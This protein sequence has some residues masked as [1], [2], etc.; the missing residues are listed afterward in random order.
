M[1]DHQDHDTEAAP[2][3]QASPPT[4][5]LPPANHVAPELAWSLDDGDA[6][7]ADDDSHDDQRWPRAL[8]VAMIALV[9]TVGIA[10]ITLGA[11]Y[12][13]QF[14]TKPPAREPNPYATFTPTFITTPPPV[15]MTAQPPAPAPTTAAMP[16]PERAAPV[17]SAALDQQVLTR[18]TSQ[19]DYTITNPTLVISNAH[20]LCILVQQH[21]IPANQAQQQVASTSMLGMFHTGTPGPNTDNDWEALTSEAMLVYPHCGTSPVN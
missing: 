16:A 5:E 13:N 19:D 3:E 21:G 2:T 7:T 6:D 17:F 10:V 20:M 8:V 11:M 15:T 18:L 4:T 1:T 9:G 14:T 12:V